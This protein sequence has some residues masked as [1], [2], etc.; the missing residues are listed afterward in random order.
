LKKIDSAMPDLIQFVIEVVS[1]IL[2]FALVG[3]MYKPFEFTREG[4]YLGLPLGF[5]FLGA[6]EVFLA[7]GIFYD[8]T[9]LRVF[10]LISRT[11]AYIFIATTYFFS[12]KPKKNSS[13]IWNITFSLIIITSAALSL[14]MVNGSIVGLE[15]PANP[16][17]YFRVIALI[18]ISY[19]FLHTLRSHIKNPDSNTI[20]IP[21]GFILLGISQYSSLIWAS[22]AHYAYGIAFAGGWITRIA[23][24]CI[25]I[26]VS[27]L[28]LNKRL[29][30]N[31]KNSA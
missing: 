9:E 29:K 8:F 15:L 18:C 16:S 14:L 23:G 30:T 19:V 24:L 20:W 17:V 6:S 13:I 25:F 28:T 2:S 3:F 7:A 10:S 31:E 26:A 27:Y 21:L 1:A 22:D 4:R 5:T 11:F 12:K